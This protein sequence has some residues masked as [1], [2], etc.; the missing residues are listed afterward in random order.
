MGN[1]NN[2]RL[3]NNYK[4]NGM[5]ALE[6]ED[7]FEKNSMNISDKVIPG[8]IEISEGRINLDL[9]G[10]FNKFGSNFRTDIYRILVF[11]VMW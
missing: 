7:L 10:S 6:L 9:N 3:N 11:Q 2:F 8:T 5:W 4:T 1:I